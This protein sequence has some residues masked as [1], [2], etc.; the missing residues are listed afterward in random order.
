MT[1]IDLVGEGSSLYG[2]N[3][4]HVL[5]L[6]ATTYDGSSPMM[7]YPCCYPGNLKRWL[8][9]HHQ[10]SIKF[11]INMFIKYFGRRISSCEE[12]RGEGNIKAAGKNIIIFLKKRE[13]GSNIFFSFLSCWEECQL[14]CWEEY[15]LGKRGRGSENVGEE[16]QVVGNFNILYIYWQAVNTHQAVCLGLQLL[17]ALKHIHKRH[18]IHK[19]GGVYSSL[20]PQR[21]SLSSLLGKNIKL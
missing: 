20:F 9:S 10:G 13:R 5:P 4:K 7:M 19:V 1:L 21:R 3:Q 16:Y 2:I 8:S 15:Q 6:I 12:A 17:T 14:G 11:H 18:I